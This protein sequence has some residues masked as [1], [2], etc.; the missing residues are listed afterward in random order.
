[1]TLRKPPPPGKHIFG[2]VR[3]GDKGQIVIPKRARELFGIN[4]GDEL[5]VLGDEGQGLALMKNERFL[6]AVTEIL[7]RMPPE[8]PQEEEK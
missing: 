5:M 8:T 7:R 6:Q 1:M 4:P 2:T 3:V